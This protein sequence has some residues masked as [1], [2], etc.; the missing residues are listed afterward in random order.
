MTPLRE[1]DI[2]EGIARIIDRC[3]QH[4]EHMMTD[5][6]RAAKEIF[7]TYIKDQNYITEDIV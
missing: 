2:K 1:E 5:Y 6:Y 3:R 7:D 4:D